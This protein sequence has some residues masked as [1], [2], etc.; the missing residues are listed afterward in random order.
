ME[1]IK[2]IVIGLIAYA[3]LSLLVIVFIKDVLALDNE[4][5]LFVNSFS[6]PYLDTFFIIV[7]YAGSSIFWLLLIVI[8]WTKN[9]KVSLY[10]L[11]AF[12]VDTLS[13][14][15]LKTF[16]ARSRPYEVFS[17]KLLAFDTELGASFPSGHTQ[18]AFSGAIILGSFY[19]KYRIPLLALGV[20]VAISRVYIGLHY[21]LDTLV[22]AINGL[23]FGMIVLNIPLKKI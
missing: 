1:L 3:L 13:Q 23:I 2:K 17:G 19:K 11:I 6:N 15:T 8:F 4:M 18:R 9:R 7:T 20:L 10:L 21:P 22:G 16:F 5:F 14:F 12:I